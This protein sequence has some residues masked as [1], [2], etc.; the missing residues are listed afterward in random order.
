[1]TQAQQNQE[2]LERAERAGST[3]AEAYARFAALAPIAIPDMFGIWRGG[4][5]PTGHRLDG[6]LETYGWFGK[7]FFS[8]ERVFPLLFGEDHKLTR[9][10]PRWLPLGLT[11]K[12]DFRKNPL[13]RTAV[14]QAMR[15]LDSKEPTARLARVDWL[16]I[17]STAMIYDR[18][19]IIDHF[20][21]V[22]PNL[23]MGL[24][25]LRGQPPFFFTLRRTQLTRI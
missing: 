9:V 21:Q 3:Q 18:L 25:D 13:P 10:N 6:L 16:G 4:G 20:R 19:P 14:R 5:L 15:L 2:W 1:M 24:M 11:E 23:L 17:G 12:W 7:A 8:E 22:T